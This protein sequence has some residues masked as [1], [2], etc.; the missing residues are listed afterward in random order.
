[1]IEHELGHGVVI[2]WHEDG[3]G[4]YWRHPECRAWMTLRFRPDPASTGHQLLAGD[5][6]HTEL[7]TIGGSLLCPVGCGR[8]GMVTSGRWVPS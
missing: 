1:V 8:H 3:R 4:I 5:H 2:A 7:L 6:Q